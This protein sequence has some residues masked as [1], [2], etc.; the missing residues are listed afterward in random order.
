MPETIDL[1]PTWAAVLPIHIV[2]IVHSGYDAKSAIHEIMRLGT[3]ADTITK[4]NKANE[5]MTTISFTQEE[6]AALKWL[7]TET[8]YHPILPDQHKEAIKALEECIK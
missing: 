6:V 3:F 5:G 7:L 4:N 8:P 2:A 1:T